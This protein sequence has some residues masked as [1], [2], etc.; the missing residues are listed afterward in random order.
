M[1]ALIF[2][3]ITVL[4]KTTAK[5]FIA[6]IS[7]YNKQMLRESTNSFH[8]FVKNRMINIGQS[9]NYY[10]TK[11]NRK[12]LR[13]KANDPIKLLSEDKAMEKGVEFVSEIIVYLI[14]IGIPIYELKKA[15]QNKSDLAIEE[16]YTFIK[17]KSNIESS[18]EGNLYL[19]NKLD[20]IDDKIN[21]LKKENEKQRKLSRRL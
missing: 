15:M 8:N 1:S 7:H 9:Y 11:F 20:E 5:P 2:K 13:L 14:I 16:K 21:R 6:W 10:Y 17:I 12:I 4:V 18:K 3:A 19:K